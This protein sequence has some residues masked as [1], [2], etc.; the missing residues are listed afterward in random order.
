MTGAF[1]QHLFNAAN[2]TG[3][4]FVFHKGKAGTGKAAAVNTNRAVI[5]QKLFAERDRKSHLLMERVPAGCD[6]L[7]KIP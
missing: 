1:A 2:K 6:V 5:A 4:G 3:K 7:E